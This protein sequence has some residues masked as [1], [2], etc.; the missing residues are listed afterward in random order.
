MPA[1]YNERSWAIDLIAHLNQ[2][3]TSQRLNVKNTG[4]ERTIRDEAG[5]LF[6]DV[7]LFGDEAGQTI[8]QGWELKMPDTSVT[9]DDLLENAERKARGLG[10][11]SFVVWNVDQAVLY[12]AGETGYRSQKSWTLPG[13]PAEKRSNVTARRSD[14]EMLAETILHDVDRLFDEGMLHERALVEAFSDQTL[15]EVLFE[16]VPATVERLREEL[17]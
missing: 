12:V 3:A 1:T 17:A 13:G 15:I 2:L 5:H 6:P 11:N 7:L 10:L 4:G 8:L 14:W 16:N 9:D